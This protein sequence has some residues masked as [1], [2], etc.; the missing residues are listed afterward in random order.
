M[1]N[2]YNTFP[3]EVYVKIVFLGA[4]IVTLTSQVG[5]SDLK[6]KIRK[7]PPQQFFPIENGIF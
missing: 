3:W 5:N 7:L 1:M 2:I 4:S 6:K